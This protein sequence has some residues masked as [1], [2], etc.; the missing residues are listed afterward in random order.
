MYRYILYKRQLQ[1]EG[2]MLQ[3]FVVDIWRYAQPVPFARICCAVYVFQRRFW[4]PK[5]LTA[6]TII[7]II[8][9]SSSWTMYLDPVYLDLAA[10]GSRSSRR[11]CVIMIALATVTIGVLLLSI[12]IV[13]SSFFIAQ[14]TTDAHCTN[15]DRKWCTYLWIR[16]PETRTR[17]G[18]Q[19]PILT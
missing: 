5:V 18:T 17:V 8:S 3:R 9:S 14:L 4:L 2:T 16:C 12:V 19:T 7:I 1:G 10:C 15:G 11:S 13:S 6:K